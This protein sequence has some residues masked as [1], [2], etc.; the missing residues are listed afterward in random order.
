MFQKLNIND[1]ILID[2]TIELDFFVHDKIQ[3]YIY[4]VYFVICILFYC[5]DIKSSLHSW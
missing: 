2:I 5:L 1:K 4:F 3:N